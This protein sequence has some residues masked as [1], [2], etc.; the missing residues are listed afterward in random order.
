MAKPKR[1]ELP[2]CPNF[3]CPGVGLRTRRD[4]EY[5]WLCSKCEQVWPRER[6][7]S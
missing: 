1:L 7:F 2:P 5:V 4:G 6:G 3:E